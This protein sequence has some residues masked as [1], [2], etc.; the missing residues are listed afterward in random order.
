MAFTPEKCNEVRVTRS[1]T[2]SRNPISANYSFSLKGHTF[3]MEDSTRY[4]G[5][6]LQSNMSWNRPMD[7]TVEKANSTLGILRRNLRVSNE[8]TK[9]AA[10][11]SRVRPILE[12]SSTTWSRYTKGYIHK[13]EMVQR[14][15]ARYVTNRYWNTSSVT[16][17]IEHLQWE[18]LKAMRAKHQLTMLLD[19][20][21]DLVDI[22]DNE[23]LTPASLFE[24]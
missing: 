22:P 9:S 5:A 1:G 17:M 16:Y 18:S 4:L 21:H 15:A 2:R 12:Y 19:I 3:K 11:F 24:V 6:E 8:G 20:I 13:I 7:Q 10:Y 14:R 23:Y